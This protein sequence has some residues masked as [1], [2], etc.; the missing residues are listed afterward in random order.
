MDALK[1]RIKQARTE[2][3]LSQSELA[4][5]CDVNPSAIN[6]LESGNT[7]SLSGALQT[8][9]ALV[10]GVSETWLSTGN[11]EMRG[12]TKPPEEVAGGYSMLDDLKELDE[13]SAER[14]RAMISAEASRART[15]KRLIYDKQDARCASCGLKMDLAEM[16]IHH[17]NPVE[18]LN[19]TIDNIALL[20]E[21]CN[22]AIK[23]NK[24]IGITKAFLM[25]PTVDDGKDSRALSA[26]TIQKAKK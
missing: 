11:G 20:C 9:I 21:P 7:R 17:I 26:P 13:E 12:K 3:K 5:R 10:C 1:T 25:L 22:M 14:F 24:K 23:L 4:R 15:L 2:A 16:N 6:H 8:S 18:I 19:T